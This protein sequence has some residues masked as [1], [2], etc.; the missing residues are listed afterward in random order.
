MKEMREIPIRIGDSFHPWQKHLVSHI[1]ITFKVFSSNSADSIVIVV[2]RLIF[3]STISI[4]F[5]RILSPPWGVLLR[6][7]AFLFDSSYETARLSRQLFWEIDNAMNMILYLVSIL[8][9]F[10]FWRPINLMTRSIPTFPDI[11]TPSNVVEPASLHDARAQRE[12]YFTNGRRFALFIIF[13]E[14]YGRFFL[15]F[16]LARV[17][18][19]ITRE[20]YLIPK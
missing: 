7:V 16:W 19:Y 10:K 17:F 18:I 11:L 4:T 12:A 15:L 6:V 13:K 2:F 20:N 1:F 14:F 8:I 5:F 9:S 3:F